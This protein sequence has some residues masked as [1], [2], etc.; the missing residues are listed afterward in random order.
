MK[1]QEPYQR[2]DDEKQAC[3]RTHCT[4]DDVFYVIVLRSSVGVQFTKRFVMRKRKHVSLT[5]AKS[6]NVR[7]RRSRGDEAH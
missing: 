7:R 6:Q 2:A 4:A 1:Q 5:Y 3:V